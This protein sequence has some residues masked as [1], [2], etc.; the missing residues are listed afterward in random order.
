MDVT[1][2]QEGDIV[3]F[4]LKGQLDALTATKA[5]Q[6]FAM[7]GEPGT[8]HGVVDSRQVTF[9]DSSGLAALISGLKAFRAHGRDFVLA[10]VQ[11]MVLQVFTLTMLDRAFRI[12]PDTTAAIASIAA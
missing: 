11:P 6:T 5:R 9:I 2:R 7:H 12:L 4:E 8:M 3:V 1:T 10:G